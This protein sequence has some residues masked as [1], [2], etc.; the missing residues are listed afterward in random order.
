MT[1]EVR[2]VFE[3]LDGELYKDKIAADN[4]ELNYCFD[5]VMDSFSFSRCEKYDYKQ[6]LKNILF[7][8]RSKE[9]MNVMEAYS[10]RELDRMLLMYDHYCNRR[11]DERYWEN[12]Q[13]F[14]K[15][16]LSL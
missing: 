12:P 5:K 3:T 6:I 16:G 9:L 14:K 7:N 1:E 4:H 10:D 8:K 11:Y 2:V 15:I 13:E